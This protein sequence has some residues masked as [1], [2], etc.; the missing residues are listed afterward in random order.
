MNTMPKEH[1]RAERP[2]QRR[3]HDP[4]RGCGLQAASRRSTQDER[5][6][7]GTQARGHAEL[8]H[9]L[10]AKALGQRLRD[11]GRD[12]IH[13]DIGAAQPTDGLTEGLRWRVVGEQRRRGVVREH[14]RGRQTALEQ[15]HQ[16]PHLVHIHEADREQHDQRRAELKEQSTPEPVQPARGERHGQQPRDAA[17]RCHMSDGLRPGVQLGR[18][19]LRYQQVERPAETEHGL[20]QQDTQDVPRDPALVWRRPL[21]VGVGVWHG[22]A[23]RPRLQTTASFSAPIRVTTVVI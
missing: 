12:G 21:D 22:S 10:P 15:K 4:L 19:K 5:H 18:K 7:K 17:H 1:A 3:D 16:R 8:E 6:R 14:E 11:R 20:R 23:A 13:R 2:D 9:N